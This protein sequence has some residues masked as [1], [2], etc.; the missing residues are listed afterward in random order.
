ME[1]RPNKRGRP[2]KIKII[3]ESQGM[4]TQTKLKLSNQ[5]KLDLLKRE[6]E[7]APDSILKKKA[8]DKLYALKKRIRGDFHK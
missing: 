8:K 3:N 6:I 2:R 7:E 5:D 1:K 4:K